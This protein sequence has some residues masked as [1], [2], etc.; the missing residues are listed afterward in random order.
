MDTVSVRRAPAES[1][2][3]R[4]KPNARARVRLF[5]LP[6]AGGG[7][8][9]YYRW[10][11]AFARD[12]EI[13]AVQLP[14]RESRLFEPR[15]RSAT[16]LAQ[17]VADAIMPYLDLP[18][19]LFGY[20]MGALLA[21]ETARA[22]RRRHAPPTHLFVAAMHAPHVPSAVPPLANLPEEELLNA[23]RHHYQPPEDALR[24]PELRDLFLPVLRDDM[25]LVDGYAYQPEPPLSCGIDA[26]VGDRDR[27]TP[28]GAAE[29]WRD[30]TV[31]PFTLNVL[32]GGH[33]FH[34]EALSV[35]RRQIASRLETVIGSRQ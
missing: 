29:R 7:A 26:Y 3:M 30:H 34:D 4:P 6:F 10:P 16:A 21:F 8:S 13:C 32:P 31:A 20:S 25:A 22:L 5:C 28:V 27:S 11:Q 2:L 9:T 17:A 35:L 33:F 15:I 24:I 14:G 18:F 19:A 12:V 1:W 23:I